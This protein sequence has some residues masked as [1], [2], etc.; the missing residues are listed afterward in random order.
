MNNTNHYKYYFLLTNFKLLK[1]MG[2]STCCDRLCA[3]DAIDK[4]FEA[5]IAGGNDDIP[6]E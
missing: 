4:H 1:K 3:I 2:M 5:R 6:H